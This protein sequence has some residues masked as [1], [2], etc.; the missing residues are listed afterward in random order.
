VVEVGRIELRDCVVF[1]VILNFVCDGAGMC[2]EG[3]SF[4]GWGMFY[5][6]SG[7]SSAEFSLHEDKGDGTAKTFG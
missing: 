6:A 5:T 2:V 4:G 7:V 1:S 3:G